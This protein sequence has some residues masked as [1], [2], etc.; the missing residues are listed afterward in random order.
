MLTSCF[1]WRPQDVRSLSQRPFKRDCVWRCFLLSLTVTATRSHQHNLGWKIQLYYCDCHCTHCLCL[2]CVCGGEELELF[3]H[4]C[5]LSKHSEGERVE[6]SACT[7]RLDLNPSWWFPQTKQSTLRTD[8]IC[9]DTKHSLFTLRSQV[10]KSVKSRR[11]MRGRDR[12]SVHSQIACIICVFRNFWK[13]HNKT[14][15]R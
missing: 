13:K 12:I 6:T 2:K 3:T 10:R 4:V 7:H 15:W 5:R 9:A 14:G 1:I 8:K 11:T